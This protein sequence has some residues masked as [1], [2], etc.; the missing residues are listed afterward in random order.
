MV[1]E[2]V[3]DSVY[4]AGAVLDGDV[5]KTNGGRVLGVTNVG[6]C[7]NCAISGAY[8]KVKKVSFGNAFYRND[9]GKKAKEAK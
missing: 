7:L 9:I 1:E 6:A 5:L 2:D 3:R 8:D 4:V